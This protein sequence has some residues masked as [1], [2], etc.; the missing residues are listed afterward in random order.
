MI[1]Q[2]W[3]SANFNAT[4]LR[5]NMQN[6]RHIRR[7]YRLLSASLVFL[8]VC[9]HL[10]Q[11]LHNHYTFPDSPSGQE[12]EQQCAS[13]AALCKICDYTAHLRHE[14][15]DIPP[16]IILQITLPEAIELEGH[17]VARIYKFTLQGFSNKGPPR[18]T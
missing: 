7:I 4:L 11:L 6:K 5:I 1:C 8:F 14:S 15:V 3:N 10:L 17:V 9:I 2:V 16:L 18:F 12:T 13:P